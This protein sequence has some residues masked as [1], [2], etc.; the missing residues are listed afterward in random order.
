[1]NKIIFTIALLGL[2]GCVSMT[3]EPASVGKNGFTFDL[4]GV[5]AVP[6]A[7]FKFQL[8]NLGRLPGAIE[9]TTHYISD[10]NSE[11]EVTAWQEQLNRIYKDNKEGFHFEKDK[12]IVDVDGDDIKT[13]LG[14]LQAIDRTESSAQIRLKKKLEVIDALNEKFK[15]S[16]DIRIDVLFLPFEVLGYTSQ[17]VIPLNDSNMK[18]DPRSTSVWAPRQSVNMW[19]GPGTIDFEKISQE[20]CTYKGAK[21]GFGVNPGFK[22]NCMGEKLKVKFGAEIHSG[23]VN[24]RL[25]HRLGYNV[26]AIHYVPELKINYDRRIMAEINSRKRKTLRIRVAGKPVVERDTLR[27]Y[28]GFEIIK[29]AHLRD[30]RTLSR[31]ELKAALV[32]SCPQIPCDFSDS[33][34]DLAFEKQIDYL[35]MN[36]SSVTEP[37]GD[38]IGP[39][40]FSNLDHP[41]RPD[42]RALMLV[43]AWTGNFDL[44]KD[45]T[46]LVYVKKSGEVK[47]FI[48]DPGSGLGAASNFRKTEG[49][50]NDFTWSATMETRVQ[51]SENQT[52]AVVMNNYKAFGTNAAFQNMNSQ[53]A[54]WMLR[55]I[56]SVSESEIS[57]A[58]AAGGLSSAEFLLAREKLISIRQKM[59]EHFGM[60]SELGSRMRSVNTRLNFDPDRQVVDVQLH[61]GRVIRLENRGVRLVNGALV[62]PQGSN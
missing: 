59:I 16:E 56:V 37:I 14:V 20:K 48:S 5:N 31:S 55:Q 30:G 40:N 47:H 51:D 35:T 12:V 42:I 34:V 25:Y 54:Q 45:N 3:R 2:I 58:L 32:K 49:R 8:L 13:S 41:Q 62:F 22:I 50:V 17:Y 53:D 11:T 19:M 21:K 23:P 38:E 15:D 39:W 29:A 1:M 52:P 9:F 4:Y 46:S 26:P 36:P 24:S 6:Q 57:E 33:N 18:L 28:D 60:K 10:A 7:D 44:R 61:D 27:I 43:G